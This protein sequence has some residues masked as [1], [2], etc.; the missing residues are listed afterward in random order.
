ME[1]S[2]LNSF[3]FN[4][5]NK[6][7]M[8]YYMQDLHI[9]QC[10]LHN[11]INKDIVGFE[12]YEERLYICDAIFNSY[13]LDYQHCQNISSTVHPMPQI[14]LIFVQVLSHDQAVFCVARE[15][16]LG[17]RILKTGHVHLVDPRLDAVHLRRIEVAVQV[18]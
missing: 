4:C 15:T 17:G 11:I 8:I 7:N 14:G 12:S 1:K 18:E 3:A 16:V 6:R 10:G 5:E 13:R 2:H 9:Q